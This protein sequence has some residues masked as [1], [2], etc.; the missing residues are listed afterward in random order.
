MIEQGHIEI[1]DKGVIFVYYGLEKPDRDDYW[2]SEGFNRAYYEENMEYYEASKQTIKV[3]NVWK[4][5][6]YWYYTDWLLSNEE[7][8]DNQP[9]KAEVTNN[10]ATIIELTKE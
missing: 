8:K 4:R 1:R 7:V 2:E 9:C 10:K 6:Q 5:Y 3:D